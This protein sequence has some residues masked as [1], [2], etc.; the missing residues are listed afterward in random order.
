MPALQPL[1]LIPGRE[2]IVLGGQNPVET[3]RKTE[4]FEG[5][6]SSSEQRPG[7]TSPSSYN[8]PAQE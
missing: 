8:S 5:P 7:L 3:P 1:L 6:L 2:N 4:F